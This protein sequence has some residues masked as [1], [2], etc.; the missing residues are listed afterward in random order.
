MKITWFGHSCFRFDIGTSVLL[1]DPFLTGNPTFAA[2][3]I[4]MATAI[5]GVTHVALTHG[6]GDHV[7]DA[8][9]IC[10]T[11]GATLLAT[12]ELAEY[13]GRQGA[14]KLERMNTGGTVC[15]PDFGLTLTDALH[16]SSSA[17]GVYLGNPNGIV[18]TPTT[19]PVV[20]HMGDTDIFP[21]MSLIDELH[22]PTIGIVPI[23]DRF[24][25]GAKAAALACR[26]YFKFTTIVPCHYGTFPGMLAATPEPFVTAMAGQNVVV[27]KI[28]VPMSV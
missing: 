10:K 18:V 3:G 25:M 17:D 23:G 20:Y 22:Q 11:T 1:I 13:V 12:Y 2:S 26:K 5:R 15:T 19:G 8:G 24:T 21:G 28:G 6:H 16:S 27:P 7:G 14:S 4:D 9:G